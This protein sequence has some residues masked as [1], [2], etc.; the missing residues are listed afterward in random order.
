M[1]SAPTQA[2]PGKAGTTFRA[3]S[4]RNA[5]IVRWVSAG[6]QNDEIGA[7]LGSFRT[8][9]EE[10]FATDLQIVGCAQSYRSSCAMRRFA[11][12]AN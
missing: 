5:E 8:Y 3:L 11:C 6:K 12:C 7:I 2:A 9:F 1:A 4:A 10:S